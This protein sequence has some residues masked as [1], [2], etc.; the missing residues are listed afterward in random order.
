MICF[1][2][3]CGRGIVRCAFFTLAC[4]G[5]SSHSLADETPAPHWMPQFLGLQAN[6]ITQRLPSMRSPY[7]GENSLPGNGDSAFSHSY[8]VSTG[9]QLTPTLQAYLDLRLQR[10]A[11]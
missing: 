8:V 10:G 2:H 7:E 3:A 6:F 5:P 11:A 1:A 9:A 4:F